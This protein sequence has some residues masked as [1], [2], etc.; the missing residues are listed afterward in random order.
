[1]VIAK[2]CLRMTWIFNYLLP[3]FGSPLL[4]FVRST[5]LI[6]IFEKKTYFVAY[7]CLEYYLTS[8]QSMRVRFQT[9]VENCPDFVKTDGI[10]SIKK[11]DTLPFYNPF[12][13]FIVFTV[14]KQN[15]GKVMFSQTCVKNSVHR[16]GVDPPTH[17]LD[18]HSRKTPPGHTHPRHPSPH[19]HSLDGH[20]S[21]WYASY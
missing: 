1:M 18:T 9:V 8:T 4:A 6:K 14:R 20:C 17:P 7:H 10:K 19:P 11:T 2:S 16:G 12:H 5:R 13:L 21:G 15:Y 3:V